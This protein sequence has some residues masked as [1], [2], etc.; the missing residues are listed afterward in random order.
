MLVWG[1]RARQNKEKDGFFFSTW[2]LP[3]AEKKLMRV[4]SHDEIT[5][6]WRQRGF[7]TDEAPVHHQQHS[8]KRKSKVISRADFLFFFFFFALVEARLIPPLQENSWVSSC[9]WSHPATA[10]LAVLALL[11]LLPPRCRERTCAWH[12]GLLSAVL[13]SLCHSLPPSTS[14]VV[15]LVISLTHSQFVCKHSVI[16]N[17][18]QNRLCRVL[19]VQCVPF[20]LLFLV[21]IIQNI[22]V[23]Y[24]FLRWLIN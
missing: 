9:C 24:N 7:R 4:K 10:R 15:S 20:W 3:R 17:R 22:L 14:S 13:F 11:R 19:K 5:A 18:S 16:V 8:I 2:C 21:Y 23:L 1:N 6:V 12:V